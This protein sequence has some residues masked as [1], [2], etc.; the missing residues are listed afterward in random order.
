MLAFSYNPAYVAGEPTHGQLV[1]TVVRIML[2]MFVVW[3]VERDARQTRYWPAYHYAL[4]VFAAWPIAVPHYILHTRGRRG[5][6]LSLLLLAAL[7]S[8]YLGWALGVGLG[9]AFGTYAW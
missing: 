4:W 3:W 1:N 7:L 6:P 5:V 9:L 8:P 2:P